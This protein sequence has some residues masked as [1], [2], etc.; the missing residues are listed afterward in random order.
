MDPAA[1]CADSS[2]STANA[3]PVPSSVVAENVA[4]GAAHLGLAPD[5]QA[6]LRMPERT[7]E[8][9]VPYTTAGGQRAVAKGYRVQHNTARGPAKGG[10]RYHP[11]VELNEVTALA[12][13]MTYKTALVGLPFGGAKGGVAVDPRRL[14]HAEKEALTRSFVRQLAPLLGPTCDVPAPDAGTDAQTMAWVADEYG[15]HASPSPAIVTGKPLAS[16]GAAGRDEATGRGVSAVTQAVLADHGVDVAGAC[17]VIQGMGNVGSHAARCLADAGAVIVGVADASAA[18][19]APGGL[20][21]EAVCRH[22]SMTGALRGYAAPAVQPVGGTELLG[23]NCDVLIPAA[24]GGVLHAGTAPDVQARFVVE[25]AN[26]PTTPRADDIL[27]DRGV[28]V[29]PDLLANAGGVTAS[30]FEW[31]HNLHGR[32]RTLAQTR[33]ELG[34]RLHDAYRTVQR[35]AAAHQTTLRTA[36]YMV[37]MRRVLAAMDREERRWARVA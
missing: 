24:L 27:A 36:A 20:D 18:L 35:T 5:V 6:S 14:C 32:A 8:I 33:I 2:A 26:L 11:D 37:G 15:R 16:G 34:R 13:V 17:V 3:C 19:H 28:V 29:V 30:F 25:G 4:R 7:L 21:V 23:L 12:E 10:L 31:E 9:K 22:V 1:R